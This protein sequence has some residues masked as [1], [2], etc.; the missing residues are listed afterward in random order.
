MKKK[1]KDATLRL[2]IPTWEMLHK[3]AF[4]RKLAGKS[5]S[6]NALVIEALEPFCKRYENIVKAMA[7]LEATK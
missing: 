6:V 2:P 4:G 1:T 3:I 5:T 7:E